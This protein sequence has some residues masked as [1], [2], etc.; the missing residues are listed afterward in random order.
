MDFSPALEPGTLERR[1]KRFLADIMLD[2]GQ[3]ITAHCANTGA[4]VGLTEPG[5]RVWVSHKK[6]DTRKYPYSWEMIEKDGEYIGVN[7]QTPPLLFKEAFQKGKIPELA[8]YKEYK[9][10]VVVKNARL[11][12]ML[13]KEN[14]D[15][16]YCE[17][18]N[19]HLMR[20]KKAFFPD[21]VTERGTRHLHALAALAAK[22]EQSFLLYVIQR[23]HCT[24]FSAAGFLDDAYGKAFIE[25]Q[26]AG[27]VFIAYTCTISPTHITLHRSVPVDEPCFS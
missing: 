26:K 19:V 20:G 16:A 24:A 7:T 25:A 2:S 23:E 12:F 6:S 8:S 14:G 17:I 15:H 22:G 21:C 11:D 4:M 18:K 10:E 1:Y 13:R 9:A 3:H 27:V 5:T